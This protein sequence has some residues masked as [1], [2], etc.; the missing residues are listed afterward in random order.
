MLIARSKKS[1][2]FSCLTKKM[3]EGFFARVYDVVQNPFDV[4]FDCCLQVIFFQ[5]FMFSCIA[6]HRI[7]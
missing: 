1:I 4:L 5:I 6:F 7:Y 3:T 2:S